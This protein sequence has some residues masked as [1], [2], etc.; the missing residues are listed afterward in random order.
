MISLFK[1][2]YPIRNI[3]FVLGEG[4]I[5]YLSVAIA[6]SILMPLEIRGMDRVLL[7]KVLL[8][9]VCCQVSFYFMNLYNLPL[10]G[11][12]IELG[13]R[14]LEALGLAAL[15]LGVTHT[16]FPQVTLSSPVFITGAVTGLILITSWRIGYRL[17]IS[18][19][20]L[21]QRVILLGSGNLALNIE[22]EIKKR[23]DCG[24]S[25]SMLI[26]EIDRVE[27]EP[28]GADLISA[29]NGYKGLCEM[30]HDMGIRKIIVAIENKRGQMPI[31]EL[32]KC[33][34]GGIEVLDGNSFYEILTGK[35]IVKS[36]NP[37]WL[38]FSNGF[39]KS[40]ITRSLKRLIDVTCA[41]IL[42]IILTPIMVIVSLAIRIDSKGPALFSQDRIGQHR[43]PYK[44][45]KFRSMVPDAELH[46]GPVWASKNDIRITRV[47][48]F[49]RKTRLDELPQLWNVL[50]GKMSFIGPR[51]EREVFVKILEKQIP[52][53]GERFSVK[54][55]ITG[56][57]QINYGYGD[58]IDDAVEKLNY[59]L[60]YIKNMSF[61]LDLLILFRTVKT[62]LFDFSGR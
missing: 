12:I 49:I 55:G 6:C 26:P 60:F 2:I 33:R 24:F 3:F 14:M 56:W 29:R 27:M 59:D 43:R 62:V 7:F 5:I 21:D 11:S 51:P 19:R 22:T 4:L 35:L 16:V 42:L 54:P 8:S 57:A 53:Y 28:I 41:I 58:S 17:L 20:Y 34:V 30:A 40:L 23:P 15:L 10:T 31:L 1:R 48:W 32:L 25:I 44:I 50:T 13:V 38:I 37:S 61:F 9:T 52:Y 47:G 18:K 36:L 39:K 46:S 45:Y